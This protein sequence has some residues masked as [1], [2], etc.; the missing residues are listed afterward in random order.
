MFGK[1]RHI[2]T[3]S[4]I[5]DGEIKTTVVGQSNSPVGARKQ[6]YQQVEKQIGMH[7]LAGHQTE[8]T[9]EEDNG[10]KTV[11]INDQTAFS[12]FTDSQ[13]FSNK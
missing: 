5:V 3:R 2:V 12:S 10:G 13:F 1:K 6:V 11:I 4:E 7:K 9:S 8:I